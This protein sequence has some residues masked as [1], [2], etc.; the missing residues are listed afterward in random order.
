MF[1]FVAYIQENLD[2]YDTNMSVYFIKNMFIINKLLICKIS[3]VRFLLMYL[4]YIFLFCVCFFIVPSRNPFR[5]FYD[6]LTRT[7]LG[8]VTPFIKLCFCAIRKKK[9][10]RH[11]CIKAIKYPNVGEGKKLMFNAVLSFKKSESS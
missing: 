4:W 9:F 7:F 6:A 2:Q 8:T 5:Q 1:I 10:D 11:L 3:L